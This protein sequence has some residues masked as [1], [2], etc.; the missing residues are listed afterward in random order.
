L[1]VLDEIAKA[2]AA[3]APVMALLVGTGIVYKY[4]PFL[5]KLPNLLIP[6][7]NA[8]IAFLSV[9]SGGPAPVEA[10]VFGDFVHHL[11]FGAKAMGSLALSVVAS[12]FYECFLRPGL[13]KAGIF[14]AGLTPMQKEAK[15]EVVK[16]G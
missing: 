9:F 6:F 3:L 4:V 15:A 12:S 7:L 16:L 10:G 1:N 2:L 14:K 8:L 5:A 13:E 11:S